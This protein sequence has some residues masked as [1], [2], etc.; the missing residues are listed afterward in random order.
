MNPTATGTVCKHCAADSKYKEPNLVNKG[1]QP[2][3]IY[4]KQQSKKFKLKTISLVSCG[5]IRIAV[6]SEKGC[7]SPTWQDTRRMKTSCVVENISDVIGPATN[8][9]HS[10]IPVAGVKNG[11]SRSYS[12]PNRE[13]SRR[14]LVAK[15]V[16]PQAK[17]GYELSI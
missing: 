7:K 1:R 16:K 11:N 4:Q 14:F 13:G 15:V 3:V 10:C 2:S 9:C 17:D 8:T 12:L 5:S 6:P